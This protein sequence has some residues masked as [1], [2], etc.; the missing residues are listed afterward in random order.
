MT[1]VFTGR[2]G[3][4]AA[5]EAAV[6]L[7]Y[8][9]LLAD[10]QVAGFFNNISIP[11]LK[12]KQVRPGRPLQ[13]GPGPCRISEDCTHEPNQERSVCE[14]LTSVDRH[15][16]HRLTLHIWS[17]ARNRRQVLNAIRSTD[18]HA[19]AAGSCYQNASMPG[20]AVVER[21][22]CNRGPS[23]ATFLQVKFLTYALGGADDYHGADPTVSHRRL[24][25]E[26][27]LRVEHFHIVVGHLQA[28]LRKLGVTEVRLDAHP[29][30]TY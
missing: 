7:F 17:R 21:E 4:H 13:V 29:K 23:L 22:R 9:R 25:N 11:R 28:T 24:H 14:R 1:C 30:D 16:I 8:K 15:F 5:V 10:D 19:F 18:R 12:A 2:L 27:G 6:E 20:L 3:G 26:K